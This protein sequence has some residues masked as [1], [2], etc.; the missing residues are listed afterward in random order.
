M[1]REILVV[2]REKLFEKKYFEGLLLQKEFD[3]E[4]VI[5]NSYEY[6]D[7]E[8]AEHDPAYK[9]P[10]A[11][12]AI[13]NPDRKKVFG[14]YRSKKSDHY[15]EKRLQGKFSIGVGGHIEKYDGTENPLQKSLEREF[16]EEISILGTSTMPKALGYLNDDSDRDNGVGKV[17]FGILYYVITNARK[18]VPKAKEIESGKFYNYKRLEIMCNNPDDRGRSSSIFKPNVEHWTK[19]AIEPIARLIETF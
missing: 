12:I 2:P 3:F 18:V 19:L 11:Y 10:I 16:N 9:Q 8:K 4:S 1:A 13:I 5:L 15:T 17:H 6:L 7:K 14:F